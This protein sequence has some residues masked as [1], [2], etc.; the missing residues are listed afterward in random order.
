MRQW[1]DHFEPC[2][3]LC[4][5]AR[6]LRSCPL[7]HLGALC[8]SC[9]ETEVHVEETFSC[10]KLHNTCKNSQVWFV[11]SAMFLKV[12]PQIPHRQGF[13][14]H[15]VWDSAS[16]FAP[17][18]LLPGSDIQLPLLPYSLLM[19]LKPIST[20]YSRFCNSNYTF[21]STNES[22]QIM[23]TAVIGALPPQQ[24]C[25]LACIPSLILFLTMCLPAHPP[26]P[27]KQHTVTLRV[28][29]TLRPQSG[30]GGGLWV[31]FPLR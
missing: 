25:I 10:M 6:Y 17:V 12:S 23:T 7:L 26:I 4:P 1:C 8:R 2:A 27:I 13:C 11:R 28:Y 18:L 22:F 16:L 5:G 29:S 30:N 19:V 3:L 9:C 31:V 20:L 15:Q 21:P 24:L 14:P